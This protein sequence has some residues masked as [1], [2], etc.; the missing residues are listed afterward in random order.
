MRVKNF[1]T[2]TALFFSSV[3]GSSTF[4]DEGMWQPHQLSELS[5]QLKALGL[6]LDPKQLSDLS[7]FPMNAIVSLGGCTASF[8]SPQGLVA[9]NHHCIY[10]SLQYNSTPENNILRDGFLA[11]SFEEEIPAAPS[12]RVYVTEAFTEVTDA[13]LAKVNDEM[14]GRE[15]YQAIEQAR[16]AL[17]AECENTGRHRCQVASFHFGL[18]YFLVKRLE[19]RDVRL[20]Y[21]PADMVGRFGGDID[22][23]QWPRHTGD[24]GFY[25]AYVGP[26]GQPADYSTDNVPYKPVAYL[27]MAVEGVQEND[28]VMALGYPGR[29]DRYRTAQ[30]VEHQFGWYYGE[31]L[32]YREDIMALILENSAEES[33]ARISYKGT[34]A[35]LSNYAKNFQSML[36]SYAQSDLLTRKQALETSVSSWIAGDETRQQQYGP[37]L[38]QL[39]ETISASEQTAARDL[40]L[41]YWRYATMASTAKTLYRLAKEK[42]KPDLEREPGYQDR[43]LP[44][45]RQ[46]LQGLNRRYDRAVDKA[47]TTYLLTRYNQLPAEQRI[48]ALDKFFKLKPGMDAQTI[49][50]SLDR[51]YKKT[52]LED[53]DARL[54]WLEKSASEFEQS[55][56]PF[57]QLAIALYDNDLTIEQAYK[58]NNGQRQRWRSAYMAALIA[59]NQSLGLPIYADANSTL[60]VTYG[61][62]KGNQPQ[63]GLINLPFTKLEGIAA[64]HRDEEP[65]AA[66]QNLLDAIN[67]KEH[68]PFALNSLQSVPVNFLSTVDITGG[69]SGSAILNGRGHLVGLLFDGVYESIIGDWDFEIET[70]RAIAV[71]V[72]YMLWV[73]RYVDN[74]HHL[75]TELNVPVN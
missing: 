69:N 48:P 17:I 58:E 19:I 29:T 57:I 49:A 33:Q 27:P 37:A 68:G 13:V 9:S 41:S 23:W 4:A 30:E 14:S 7:D 34:Y 21:S 66:P 31:A 75:L 36:Q 12:S 26:D 52:E 61:Q 25:R 40:L 5:P 62:V 15:R 63:D 64:K 10:G 72:R 70:N 74:A 24:F 55:K 71:D 35:G 22:N 45:T 38:T 1:F 54:S 32:G 51:M 42:E 8:V 73:M 47:I 6:E 53:K 39:R 16:K 65:F 28:F 3:I 59:Y 44:F 46:Y 18:Q 43:D 11:N 60:R 2:I 50:K 56:D 67:A 20:V